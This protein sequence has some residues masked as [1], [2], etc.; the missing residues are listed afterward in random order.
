[1]KTYKEKEYKMRTA[2][3]VREEIDKIKLSLMDDLFDD[4]LQI[5]S[6]P[7]VVSLR[8]ARIRID[9]LLWVLGLQEG[10]SQ[11]RQLKKLKSKVIEDKNEK[12]EN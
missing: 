4:G 1:M 7:S 6:R 8:E 2:I 11:V 10:F 5:N 12:S 9:T 3:E